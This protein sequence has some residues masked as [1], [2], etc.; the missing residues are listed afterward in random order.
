MIIWS[1]KT[2]PEFWAH[3]YTQLESLLVEERNWVKLPT[4][5][6]SLFFSLDRPHQVTNCAN[7]ASLIY[8]SLLAFPACF[9][10]ANDKAVNWCGMLTHN[11][12]LQLELM[13]M[14]ESVRCIFALILLP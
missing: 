3:V 4:V 10:S 8:N 9:G 7:A 14:L 6:S 2:K 13:G 11:L 5:L 12:E 1:I